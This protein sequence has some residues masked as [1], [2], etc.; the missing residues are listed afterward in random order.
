MP[1]T[2]ETASEV[3][4]ELKKLRTEKGLSVQAAAVHTKV[5]AMRIYAI[6]GG[7]CG[8]LHEKTIRKLGEGY[9]LSA[10]RI[11]DIIRILGCSPL[12]RVTQAEFRTLQGRVEALEML[13][14]SKSGTK[15]K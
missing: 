12:G 3:C 9:G 14:T 15:N 2:I 10:Q 8:R 1:R 7:Y 11:E 5:S 13:M 6:E 4:Q